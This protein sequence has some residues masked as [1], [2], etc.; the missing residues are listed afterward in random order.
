MPHHEPTV[1]AQVGPDGRPP[2]FDGAAW[3]SQDGRY[4]WNGAA[5]QPISRPRFRLSGLVVVLAIFVVAGL[6]FT[7]YKVLSPKPFEGDGVSNARIDSR[8]EIEFDYRRSSTCSNLTFVYRFFDSADK[9]VD[10][11]HDLKGGRVAGGV[12]VHYDITGDPAQPIDSRAARFVA[13]ATC[14][15]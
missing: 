14:H 4:F 8:T 5:W 12:T 9:Q 3:V 11:F 1:D 15:D 2:R 6:G 13:D 7:I 10:I